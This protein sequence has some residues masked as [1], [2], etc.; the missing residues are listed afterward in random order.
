MMEAE[1]EGLNRLKRKLSAYRRREKDLVK[2]F[3]VLRAEGVEVE[4]VYED[5]VSG[6]M[7][8]SLDSGRKMEESLTRIRKEDR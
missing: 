4:K 1:R 8:V 3:A 5:V 7:E 6:R 2:V